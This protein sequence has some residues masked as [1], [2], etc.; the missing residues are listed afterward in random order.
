MY[1]FIGDLG[2]SEKL[3]FKSEVEFGDSD[4]E[5]K[6]YERSGSEK[7]TRAVKR[8]KVKTIGAGAFGRGTELAI[9][10]RDRG[11]PIRPPKLTRP[12]FPDLF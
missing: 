2:F 1:F 7:A 3:K 9:R 12:L 4:V 6:T 8:K 10:R 5:N 11:T